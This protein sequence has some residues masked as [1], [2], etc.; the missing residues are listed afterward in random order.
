MLTSTRFSVLQS[1]AKAIQTHVHRD[2]T[3]YSGFFA[4]VQKS[5]R[6]VQYRDLDKEEAERLKKIVDDFVEQFQVRG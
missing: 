6:A 3:K 1:V 4:S 2:T 5:L